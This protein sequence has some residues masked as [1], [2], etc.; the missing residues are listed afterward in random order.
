MNMMKINCQFKDK[1]IAAKLKITCSEL[2]CLKQY[3]DAEV[4]SV[5]EFQKK[6][7]DAFKNLANEIFEEKQ[8][9]N[10]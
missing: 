8:M 4:L 3:F 5:K 10:I 2:N 1:K 9:P 7:S 6:F